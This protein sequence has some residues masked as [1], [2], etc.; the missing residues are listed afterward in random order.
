[1]EYTYGRYRDDVSR[2]EAFDDYWGFFMNVINILKS[3]SE[4]KVALTS[5]KIDDANNCLNLEE[6]RSIIIKH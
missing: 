3:E 6:F 2:D 5:K 4:Y 1:M